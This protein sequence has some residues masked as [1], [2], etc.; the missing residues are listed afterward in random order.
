[1]AD[2]AKPAVELL[3]LPWI[4]K[5]TGT[6]E[7][8]KYQSLPPLILTGC[9]SITLTLD[10]HGTKLSYGRNSALIFVQGTWKYISLFDFVENGKEGEQIV[11]IPLSKFPALDIKLPLTG[12]REQLSLRIWTQAGSNVEI[13]S[14]RLHPKAQYWEIQSFDWMKVTKDK[15]ANPST[16]AFIHEQARLAKAWGA[17]TVAIAT[18][19]D[20]PP[21]TNVLLFTQRLVKILA[22][23]DL[24]VWHRHMKTTFEGHFPGMPKKYNDNPLQTMSNFIINNPGLFKEGQIFTPQPEPESAGIAGVVGTGILPHQ[25][26]DKSD[27]NQWI[28]LAQ[29]VAKL[30]FAKIGLEG[31]VKIGYYGHSGFMVFGENNPD[32]L[33]KSQLEQSTV[34]AM[35]GVIAMDVYPEFYNGKMA[36]VLD[37][38]HAMWP[39]AKF[40]IGEWGTVKPG[41]PE[42][43]TALIKETMTAAIRPYVIGFNYWTM[44]P[45]GEEGLVDTQNN[46]MPWSQTVSDF[47]HGKNI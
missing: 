10:L 43:K 13:K 15:T 38:A 21:G 19:Y 25:F 44:G 7:V 8:Q 29:S 14:I 42:Q 1:M 2:I 22:E 30:S 6:G 34:D 28:R 31:K 36:D 17:N 33:G 27:Y 24:D 12:T 47:Y 37:R 3:T 9:E 40:L 23:Y 18:P 5:R 41:T 39:K 16:D 20:S 11:N 35:D 32:W 45:G 4:L 26:K 46:P